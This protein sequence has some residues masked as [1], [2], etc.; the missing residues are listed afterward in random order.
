MS[1]PDF[2]LDAFISTPTDFLF[3]VVYSPAGL[4]IVLHRVECTLLL[5]GQGTL[6][7]TVLSTFGDI[8]ST[9]VD[10]R[11]VC[12]SAA[13]LPTFIVCC[14]TDV[15]TLLVS[16]DIQYQQSGDGQY[17]DYCFGLKIDTSNLTTCIYGIKES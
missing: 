17:N 12:P 16:G 14:L 11:L 7:F 15:Q 10:A 8:L 1:L 3:P 5:R 9:S 2:F 4:H 6:R 13:L